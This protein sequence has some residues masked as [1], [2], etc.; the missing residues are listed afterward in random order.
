MP[1][2]LLSK[3]VVDGVFLKDHAASA[4][5]NGDFVSKPVM[6]GTTEDELKMVDNKSGTRARD[7]DKRGGLP[8]KLPAT[9]W[10]GGIALC[11]GIAQ[12][13]SEPYTNAV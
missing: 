1:L 12:G 7:C 10:A 3:P 13:I 5:R 11:R 8:Q 9:I 2:E 4:E 6:L